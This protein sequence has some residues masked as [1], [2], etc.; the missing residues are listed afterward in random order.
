MELG[1]LDAFFHTSL[2][3]KA[4]WL[5]LLISA[6]LALGIFLKKRKE[7]KVSQESNLRVSRMLMDTD[8][9]VQGEG[10]SEGVLIDSSFHL[11][12]EAWQRCLQGESSYTNTKNLMDS[13]AKETLLCLE[14][15]LSWLASIASNAPFVGL[16]GTVMGI[17]H[18]FQVIGS[19]GNTSLQSLGPALAE[20][21]YATGIGLAVAILATIFYNMLLENIKEFDTHL[22]S[23]QA[24]LLAVSFD[25]DRDNSSES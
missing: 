6:I 2:I 12:V 19:T 13:A 9:E 14:D 17:I 7:F 23:L 5:L 4:I 22:N 8:Y 24:K 1:V 20:A 10:F 16:L 25:E 11:T 18:A 21:L 3:G 15:N